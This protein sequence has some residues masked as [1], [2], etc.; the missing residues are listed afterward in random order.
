MSAPN[1]SEDGLSQAAV[2]PR[3]GDVAA[4]ATVVEAPLTRR[5]GLAFANL[6]PV[7]DHAAL[8]AGVFLLVATAGF[9]WREQSHTT[10]TISDDP[11]V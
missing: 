5:Y 11:P 8:V 9:A 3:D 4:V 2:H 1:L 7:A 6:R 10:A